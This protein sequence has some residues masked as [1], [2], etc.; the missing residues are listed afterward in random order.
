MMLNSA[1]GYG[2]IGAKAIL[3]TGFQSIE[4]KLFAAANDGLV[5]NSFS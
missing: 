1:A 4:S 5:D 3:V 2:I